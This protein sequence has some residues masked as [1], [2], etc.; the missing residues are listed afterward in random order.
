MKNL[1]RM[2]SRLLVIIRTLAACLAFGKI[3][4]HLVDRMEYTPMV[5]SVNLIS[6]EMLLTLIARLASSF[7]RC[8]AAMLEAHLKKT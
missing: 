3:E 6:E 1:M 2:A 4:L 8:R 5:N 7:A